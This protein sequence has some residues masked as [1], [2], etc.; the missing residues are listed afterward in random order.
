MRAD[1]PVDGR[2]VA[3]TQCSERVSAC[4][5]P[6]DLGALVDRGFLSAGA[7]SRRFTQFECCRTAAVI[8]LAHTFSLVIRGRPRGEVNN[9]CGQ[10]C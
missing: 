1:G 8:G 4:V 10:H 7:E 6:R 9:Q 2:P 5:P 3:H